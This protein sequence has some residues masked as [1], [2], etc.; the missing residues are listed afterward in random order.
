MSFYFQYAIYLIYELA[1]SYLQDPCNQP[2]LHLEVIIFGDI[3]S[4]RNV[5]NWKLVTFAL[6]YLWRP[7]TFLIFMPIEDCIIQIEPETPELWWSRKNKL[8]FQLHCPLH[9]RILNV[10]TV[11][12]GIFTQGSDCDFYKE[13]ISY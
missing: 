10:K 5:Y 1:G 8:V 13:T 7:N 6:G 3:S 12:G 9:F 2:Q 4:L 11:N